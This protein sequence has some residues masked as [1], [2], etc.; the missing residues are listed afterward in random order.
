MVNLLPF[1]GALDCN[2]ASVGLHYMTD[3]RQAQTAPLGVVHQGITY[4]V[5]FLENFGLLLG[6]NSDSVIDD[7]KVHGVVLAVE[8][9]PEVLFRQGVLQRVVDQVEQRTGDRL[10]IHEQRRYVTINFLLELKTA[11]LDFKPVRFE[12]GANQ[13]GYVRS[14]KLYSFLPDSMR[15]KSR[16]L[17]IREVS[18]SLSL[19]MIS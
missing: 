8:F 19:R 11:L 16:M 3:E 13:I 5:E 10:T 9:Y 6:G 17:L 15:E 1:P 14:R 18:R 2:L 4:P 12:G 7:F